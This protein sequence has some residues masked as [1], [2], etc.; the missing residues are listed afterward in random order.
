MGDEQMGA[1]IVEVFLGDIPRQIES[2][3]DSIESA[4]AEA[5]VR[6]AHSIKGAA[7]SVSGDAL[8]Q[9]ALEME[10]AGKAGGPAAMAPHLPGLLVTFEQTRREMA[11]FAKQ[12][13][14]Q[15]TGRI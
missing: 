8:R 2:L 11:G 13:T 7:A 10:K 6:I 12:N 4:D 14:D 15:V 3:K 1:S 9:A 5:C